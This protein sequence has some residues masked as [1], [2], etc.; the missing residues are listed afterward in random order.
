MSHSVPDPLR[1]GEAEVIR[2][3]C[4]RS[5]LIRGGEYVSGGQCMIR[6]LYVQFTSEGPGRVMDGDRLLRPSPVHQSWLCHITGGTPLF[7]FA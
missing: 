7:F 3:G 6:A 4:V 2:I 5:S 1:Y